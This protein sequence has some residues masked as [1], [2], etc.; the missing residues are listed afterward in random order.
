MNQLL[1]VESLDETSFTQDNVVEIYSHTVKQEGE[2][3]AND[4][5]NNPL[6]D[7]LCDTMGLL[8]GFLSKNYTTYQ[9]VNSPNFISFVKSFKAKMFTFLL[10][11]KLFE[12][13]KIKTNF[14][15][16]LNWEITKFSELITGSK[17]IT[18][19]FYGKLNYN[20]SAHFKLLPIRT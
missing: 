5:T 8:N 18:K 6:V 20:S 15:F 14:L 13:D 19:F 4:L 2:D 12:L 3:V 10:K 17:S 1:G 9:L 7:K 11:S 16:F